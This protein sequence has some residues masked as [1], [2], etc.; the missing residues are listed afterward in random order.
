MGIHNLLYGSV[1]RKINLFCLLAAILSVIVFPLKKEVWYDETISIL[2]SK[3]ISHDSHLLF[4]TNDAVSSATINALNTAKNVHQATVVDNG[5]S[6]LYNE[7]LHW[8]TGLAGN[9][10]FSYTLFTKLASIGVLIALYVLASLFFGNSI[11]AS[12]AIVLLAVD[13]NYVSM[14]NEV[15]AYTMAT[16]FITLAGIN[17]Y[18]Y[19]YREDKAKYLLWLG[20]F[21]AAAVLCH[22]LSVYIVLVFVGYLLVYKFRKLLISSSLLAIVVPVAIVG[23]YFLFS[24]RGLVTM[25]S[26]N[27]NI[28]RATVNEGFSLA[29]VFFRSLHLSSLDFNAVFSAFRKTRPVIL[30]SFLSVLT[31]YIAAMGAA[32]EKTDKRNL[33]LLFLLGLSSTVF[34]ALLSIKS[35]HYTALYLRYHSFCLPYGALFVAYALSVLA[36]NN[37]LKPIIKIAAVC[38]FLLPAL[39]L[40]A[41][42][43]RTNNAIRIYNHSVVALQIQREHIT[44]LGVPG[45]REAFLVNAFLPRDYKIDYVRKGNGPYFTLYKSGK[46]E[47]VPVLNQQ[48]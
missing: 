11:F 31:L 44:T 5:N 1:A 42:S 28:Q 2:C 32:T 10:M 34:L 15:R 47:T 35:R 26:Q 4:A 7:G 43:V 22:F 41:S 8:F 36:K 16:F 39:A 45:W 46:E 30:F 3:G 37:R 23:I 20:V 21:S 38:F 48:P 24:Y 19:M 18:K 6:F 12:L 33:N 40:Y 27:A 9:S 14:G 25:S 29:E 13:T 17:F